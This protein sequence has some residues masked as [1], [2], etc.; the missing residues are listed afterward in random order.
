MPSGWPESR[1]VLQIRPVQGSN[2]SLALLSSFCHSW[3]MAPCVPALSPVRFQA[4]ASSLDPSFSHTQQALATPQPTSKQRQLLGK[5]RESWAYPN[6]FFVCRFFMHAR[7]C[8]I[9]VQY[10]RYVCSHC[11]MGP[12]WLEITNF[13]GWSH[14][15]KLPKAWERSTILN[16]IW[17]IKAHNQTQKILTS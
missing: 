1:D 14:R 8:I 7:G 13:F 12:A 6:H 9:Q 3:H 16:Y 4:F 15:S 10:C 2:W 17:T 5:P 11:L